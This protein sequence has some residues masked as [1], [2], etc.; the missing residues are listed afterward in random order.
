MT[1]DP[2][3]PFVRTVA[4]SAVPM[5]VVSLEGYEVLASSPPFQSAVGRDLV[6]V[7]WLVGQ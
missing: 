2:L 4:G 7:V 5:A 6:G 3:A 1:R